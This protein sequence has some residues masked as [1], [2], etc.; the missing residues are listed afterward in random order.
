MTCVQVSVLRRGG[1]RAQENG[2]QITKVLLK[3][4]FEL[5]LKILLKNCK[6]IL[7]NILITL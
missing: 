6:E 1:S 2:V 7:N 5:G 4:L 3:K